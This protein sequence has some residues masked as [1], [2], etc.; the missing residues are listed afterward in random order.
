MGVLGA[1]VATV[2]TYSVYT[3]ANVYVIRAELS[4]SL[5]RLATDTGTICIVT[6]GMAL[7]V[8]A[9]LPYV[10]GVATL[11]AVVAAGGAMW[12]VLSVLTGLVAPRRVASLL[13]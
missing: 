1:A 3:G 7:L 4:P 11:L 10:T 8:L 6:G 12:A 9:L 5:G 2:V 13:S